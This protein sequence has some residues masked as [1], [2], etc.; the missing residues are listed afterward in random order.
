[1]RTRSLTAAV[2]A[3]LTA[4]LTGGC[5]SG[6]ATPAA[7]ATPTP[8]ATADVPPALELETDVVSGSACF[9]GLRKPGRSELAWLDFTWRADADLESFE[10]RLIGA[11][12][13]RLVGDSWTVPPV[14]FGGRIAV[15]GQATWHGWKKAVSGPQVVVDQGGPTWSWSPIEGETGLLVLHVRVDP[16][17]LDTPQ[18]GGVDAVAL[19]YVTGTGEKGTAELDINDTW[20]GERSCD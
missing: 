7:T 1:M 8:S 20:Y 4:S 3:V 2:C 15:G 18:G 12:G 16:D 17:V 19:D 14:N 5:S 11:R 9:A 10:P 6:D 13:V